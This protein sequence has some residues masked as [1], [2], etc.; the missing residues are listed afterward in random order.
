VWNVGEVVYRWNY[1]DHFVLVDDL[2][3]FPSLLTMLT[4]WGW[5]RST[6][7]SAAVYLIVIILMILI[8]S[9][10][11]RLIR[12]A[13]MVFKSS[14]RAGVLGIVI[15]VAA[16]VQVLVFS[17]ETPTILLIQSFAAEPVEDIVEPE[18][19]PSRTVFTP[20]QIEAAQRTFEQ[21][22]NRSNYAYPGIGDGDIHLLVVESYGHTLFTNPMH[23]DNI[24]PVLGD[25][26]AKLEEEGWSARSGFLDS[27]AFG[28]RSWLADATLITGR[29]MTNQR[30]F[31]GHIYTGDANLP[32]QMSAAGYRT[33]Y[34]A[35]GTRRTPEDWKNYY[36]YDDLIIEGDFGWEGPFISFGNMSDQFLLNTV[37]R[38]YLESDEP[39]FLAAL[40]VSSH[41]PFVR[42]PEYIPDWDR[43]GDGSLY[44]DE[45][46]RR[47]NNNWLG[48]SEY[49][50][51][52]VYS[53]GYVLETIAGY[54][55][56]YADE[57]SLV[58][59]VGDHQPRTPISEASATSGVPVHFLSKTAAALTPLPDEFFSQGFIPS[60]DLPLRPMEDFPDFLNLVLKPQGALSSYLR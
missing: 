32:G 41:V 49:P 10:L 29:R 5:F 51:G 30:I 46:I 2:S 22:E 53:I 59:I 1:R 9:M 14:A 23:R 44:A 25:I 8:G 54:M 3:L 58:V 21:M 6:L 17:Q 7:G 39:V 31:D 50:E 57:D 13:V 43:L 27:P 48:G 47:F 26:S 11:L 15:I 56:R 35:P 38:R 18:S 34:A 20:E 28:G 19:S 12:S 60:D 16:C 40:L 45:G 4:R 24:R 37:G 36:G 55:E 33:V 52:Y 42:I